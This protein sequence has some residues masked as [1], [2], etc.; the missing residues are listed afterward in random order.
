MRLSRRAVLIGISLVG[1]LHMPQ[2][3]FRQPTRMATPLAALL[4]GLTDRRGAAAIGRAYFAGRQAAGPGADLPAGQV[5]RLASMAAAAPSPARLA[6]AIGM[7][8][9]R[10]FT[11]GE[12]IRVDGWILARSEAALCALA[13][14]SDRPEPQAPGST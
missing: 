2:R 10:E 5:R 6:D 9:R 1:L 8:C 3:R 4:G 11:A 13:A 12:V 7:Q 14:L